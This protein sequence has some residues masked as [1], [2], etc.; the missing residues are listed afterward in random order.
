ML[1]F[2]GLA[3][4]ADRTGL[5]TIRLTGKLWPFVMIAFGL[6]R[7]LA[8]TSGSEHPSSRWPGVWFI[9]LGLWFLVNEFRVLGLWYTTSWPLL[10]VGAGIGMIWR[11]IEVSERGL[12]HRIKGG[13]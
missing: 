4:L 6:S 10:I 12:S 8:A 13:Q 5:S 3:L 1:A 9:Y 2:T 11:A 7:L